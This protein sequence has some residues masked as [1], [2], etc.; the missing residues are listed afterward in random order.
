MLMIE[1]YVRKKKHIF[2]AVLRTKGLNCSPSAAPSAVDGITL[3]P[4]GIKL[5]DLK[6]ELLSKEGSYKVC[7]HGKD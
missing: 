6:N 3:P 7:M 1:A 2:Y 4:S 5:V